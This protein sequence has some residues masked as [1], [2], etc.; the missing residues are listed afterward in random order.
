MPQFTKEQRIEVIKGIYSN[1]M[2]LGSLKN[3]EAGIIEFLERIFPLRALPSTDS[4]YTNARDDVWK[5]MVVNADW[6]YEYLF[7]D[8]FPQFYQ[9]EATFQK[10]VELS[11]HPSFFEN[12]FNRQKMKGD[13]DD[14]LN[15][16]GLCLVGNDYFDGKLVYVISQIR[17]DR[18]PIPESMPENTIPF[19][20]NTDLEKKYPCFVLTDVD[21]NDWFKWH[22]KFLLEYWETSDTNHRMGHLKIMKKGIDKTC[23]VLPHYFKLLDDEYCSLGMEYSYYEAVKKCVGVNYQSVL[24][25]LRDAAILPLVRESFEEDPCFN[26]SIIRDEE[27]HSNPK[28]LLDSVRY[29]LL[30]IN[31]DDYYKFSYIYHPPFQ[32]KDNDENQIIDFDFKY[33]VPF[34]QRIIAVIGRNGSGKTTLLTRMANSFQEVNDKRILPSAP[35]YNKVISISFSIFDTL[36]FPE[37]NARFNYTYLGLQKKDGNKIGNLQSELKKHLNFINEKQRVGFWIRF[38]SKVMDEGTLNGMFDD[39]EQI[40]FVENVI[41]KLEKLSSGENLLMYIFSSLLD[42]IKPNTL[43]LYDEPEM[44]LHPNAISRLIHY[45]Y[46][47]LR[48][49]NSFCIIATHSPLVVREIPAENVKIFRRNGDVLDVEPIAVE[50]FSENLSRISECVFGDELNQRYYR[51][52]IERITK[53][54]KNYEK[55]IELLGDGNRPVPMSTRMMV[56]S[57]LNEL[58]EKPKTNQ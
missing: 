47:L 39:N 44:H 16:Y 35:L 6:D 56:K 52:V 15:K 46:I 58:N 7:L 28:P 45:L 25:A 20:Y 29:R 1:D 27:Y 50:T 43:V 54:F 34:E 57:I 42:E 49:Y 48:E 8:R 33:N 18:I 51:H 19:Y 2:F 22:T 31:V 23:T 12:E 9:D 24:S 53:E 10:F 13:V 40:I 5:H 17:D 37:K 4:R 32:P 30:G 41:K 36:P 55:V 14:L 3:E 11:V 26:N 38:L 21:W